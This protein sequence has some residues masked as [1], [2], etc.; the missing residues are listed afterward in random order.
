MKAV[1]KLSTVKSGFLLANPIVVFFSKICEQLFFTVNE[2][3]I[4][5]KY[6]YVYTIVYKINVR[7]PYP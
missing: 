2:Y 1:L 6:I 4:K 5:K 3:K 7:L